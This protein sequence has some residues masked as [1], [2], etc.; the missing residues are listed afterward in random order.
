MPISAWMVAMAAIGPGCGG[1]SPC[2]VESP[3]AIGS[4][5]RR[6]GVRVS[7]ESVKAIGPS[8][9]MPTPKKTVMPMRK[10]ISMTA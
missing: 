6:M 7:R 3:A 8:S 10:A 1:M 4:A 5:S 9:T 2:A